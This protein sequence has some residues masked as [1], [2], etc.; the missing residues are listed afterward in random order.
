M[1][2]GL[3]VLIVLISSWFTFAQGNTSLCAVKTKMDLTKNCQGKKVQ[4]KGTMATLVTAH[5]DMT[6]P[7]YR[8]QSYLDTAFG[9]VVL[10]SGKSISCRKKL[11]V[12]GILGWKDLGGAAGT[13]DSYQNAFVA[14]EKFTC[15]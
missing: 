8:F 3:V 2:I 11:E 4:L 1:K 12:I 10:V 5:P 14:V 13:R 6:T 9:Q 7:T 15:G